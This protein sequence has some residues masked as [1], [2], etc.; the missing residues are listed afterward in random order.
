MTSSS[1]LKTMPFIVF[2]CVAAGAFDRR[3]IQRLV[4]AI[5]PPTAGASRPDGGRIALGRIWE[6]STN[7][8]NRGE[9]AQ[10]SGQAIDTASLAMAA[11][12]MAPGDR[13]T[14]VRQNRP[15]W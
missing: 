5:T 1:T 9:P 12:R 10:G 15:A 7:R 6:P 8:A 13:R 4:S 14:V 3:L 2:P 11:G